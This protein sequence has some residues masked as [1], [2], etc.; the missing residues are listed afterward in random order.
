MI[1]ITSQL[2]N[3]QLAKALTLLFKSLS[4]VQVCEL[5]AESAHQAGNELPAYLGAA[6]LTF[7]QKLRRL[8]REEEESELNAFLLSSKTVSLP[9]DIADDDIPTTR[10]RRTESGFNTKTTV[11][12]VFDLSDQDIEIV[13]DR[14]TDPCLR[15][16]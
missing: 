9:M 4:P 1:D 12:Y 8:A 15:S 14:P 11:D 10:Y 16:A 5:M 2:T 3:R 7:A 13:D 6:R